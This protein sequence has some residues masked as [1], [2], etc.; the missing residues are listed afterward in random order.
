MAEIITRLCVGGPLSGEFLATLDD[1]VPVCEIQDG[2][3]IRYEKYQFIVRRPVGNVRAGVHHLFVH[4]PLLSDKQI[5]DLLV[6]AHGS[7]N[8]G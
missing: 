3:R 6:A 1:V 2:S 5:L 7:T 8:R 4:G